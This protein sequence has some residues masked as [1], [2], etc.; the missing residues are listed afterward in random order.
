MPITR[1]DGSGLGNAL[2]GVLTLGTADASPYGGRFNV[3]NSGQ[4]S[5][6]FWNLGIGS[7][8]V[9][10]TASSSNLRLYNTY[11]DGL[12]P[13]GRG[14]DIDIAGRTLNPNQPAFM[15]FHQGSSGTN[16]AGG[17]AIVLD[18][19][20]LNVGSA[21]NAS[22]GRYTCPAT[23][24]YQFFFGTIKSDN[25]VAPDGRVSR[26]RIRRNASQNLSAELR[27]SEN[28]GYGESSSIVCV[29]QCNAGDFIDIFLTDVGGWYGN[30]YAHFGGHLIG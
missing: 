9:G 4:A 12:M 26:F 25:G 16:T 21:Y 13:N 2:T 15:V 23:G 24:V 28:G 22:T 3:T 11:N 5:A 7:G 10:F 1:I 18:T 6:F 20:I 8:H 19:P 29:A 14:I 30:T 17:N 27:L